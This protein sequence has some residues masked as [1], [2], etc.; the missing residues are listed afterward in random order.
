MLNQDLKKVPFQTFLLHD[1]N[2][3]AIG[4]YTLE[5][6]E[7]LYE[8]TEKT[9]MFVSKL[10]ILV[11]DNAKLKSTKYGAES[12]LENGIKIY[13]T[14]KDGIKNYII[15]NLETVRTNKEWLQY[16]C[17][18]EQDTFADRET[19]LRITFNFYKE[20]YI[21]LEKGCKF[22]I[23]LNDNFNS[24]EKQTFH[25]SGFKIKI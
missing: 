15:G 5:P 1:G 22:I 9:K 13:Y 8:H 12:N 16:N 20:T 7:F 2:H 6:E 14:N 24:L 25:I 17:K 21:I 19:F 23:E 3:E 4:D 11:E 10:T 18:V